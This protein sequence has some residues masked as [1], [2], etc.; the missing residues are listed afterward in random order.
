MGMHIIAYFKILV[1][2]VDPW[3]IRKR[4]DRFETDSETTDQIFVFGTIFDGTDTPDVSI[5]ERDSEMR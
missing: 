2:G 3:T 1:A 4:I 5:V